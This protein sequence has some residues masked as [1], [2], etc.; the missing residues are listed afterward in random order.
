MMT[1]IMPDSTG[2]VSTIVS[3]SWYKDAIL[4]KFTN[5]FTTHKSLARHTV[6]GC[7]S[8]GN[9]FPHL[10][11]TSSPFS[12]GNQGGLLHRIP[13]L[14]RPR[15]SIM[16]LQVSKDNPF[17]YRN[18]KMTEKPEWWWTIIEQLGG[19]LGGSIYYIST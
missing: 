5:T 19:C 12:S 14:P 1:L 16:P 15:K 9:S 8:K 11:V 6:V 4:Q 13:L 10:S 18:P 17:G 2:T 3:S 7:G